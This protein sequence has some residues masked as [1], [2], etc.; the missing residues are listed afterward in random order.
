MS[1]KLAWGR[2]LGGS[3][4]TDHLIGTSAHAPQCPKVTYTGIGTFLKQGTTQCDTLVSRQHSVLW[5]LVSFL[6]GLPQESL[7]PDDR[8]YSL[9][10][11]DFFSVTGITSEKCPEVNL[12]GDGLMLG[13]PDVPSKIVIKPI[14][15]TNS[16]SHEFSREDN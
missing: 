2:T 14:V 8:V 4:R 16:S 3:L 7:L 13:L 12:S 5:Y 6:T 11:F 9:I 15:L 1:T 10:G